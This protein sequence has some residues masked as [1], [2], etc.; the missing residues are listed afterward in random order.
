[1]K[2]ILFLGDSLTAGYGLPVWQAYPSLI[3][4]K[5]QQEGYS[6]HV[7]NAGLSGDTS[8]GGLH[9]LGHWLKEPVAIFVLALGANDGLRGIPARETTQNLQQIIDKV[10]LHSP[11]AKIVLSGMEIPDI[12][13][14]RYAAEFR[15]LFRE[16]AIKN[17]ISFIP[18]LL[19]GVVGI[20]NLNLPDG[21]H[22]N[23]EGH[24]IL[25]NHT[26]AVLEGLL[27]K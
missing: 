8:A 21:I 10:Q 27:E 20:R 16:L 17:N 25:A 3:Q 23:A 14:G 9:R 4:Q 19:E 11:E 18:F 6:Y 22:P 12:V 15:K 5:L 13:P 2:N 24:K 7:I 1:M 26:W